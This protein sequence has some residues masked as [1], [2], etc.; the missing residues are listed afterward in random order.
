MISLIVYSLGDLIARTGILILST[1]IVGSSL[2]WKFISY[3]G[4][5]QF[6]SKTSSFFSVL[7]NI[8]VMKAN[9]RMNCVEK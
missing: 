2:S 7:I 4:F 9:V 1:K 8:I 5:Y 3:I 6:R